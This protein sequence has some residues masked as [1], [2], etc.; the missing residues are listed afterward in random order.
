MN[1]YRPAEHAGIDPDRLIVA[2]HEIGHVVGF[3]KAG[4]PLVAIRVLRAGHRAHG[5]VQET[6][7]VALSDREAA[8]TYLVALLAGK[9]AGL[10][11]CDEY[12]LDYGQRE[13]T[14]LDGFHHQRRE[15]GISLPEPRARDLARRLV[16]DRWAVIQRLAPVLAARGA[17]APTIG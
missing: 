14:D 7:E 15:W 17:L 16:I 2:A 4:V 8:I 1:R 11:W 10:A 5:Y 13:D 9:E 12:G 6:G 3:R